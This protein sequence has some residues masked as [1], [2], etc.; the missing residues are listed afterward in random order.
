MCPS[1]EDRSPMENKQLIKVLLI[2]DN[3]I[4]ARLIRKML[5]E[6][7][8]DSNVIFEY[9]HADQL[10]KGFDYLERARID[11]IL[12]D[13]GLADSQGMDTLR[14]IMSREHQIPII[15]VTGLTD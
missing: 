5:Y 15:V 11:V 8:E 1:I 9:F 6:D 2:E 12:L 3:P 10:S 13:L 4:D 14:L 7:S